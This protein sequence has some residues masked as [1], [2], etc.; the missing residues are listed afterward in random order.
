MQAVNVLCIKWGKKYGPEYVNKLHNMVRR[1][2]KRPFRFVCLT[3]DTHGID[4][5]S[6]V[7]PIPAIGFDE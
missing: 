4:P 5:Q 6:E 1:N 2:L 7:Q 3:D